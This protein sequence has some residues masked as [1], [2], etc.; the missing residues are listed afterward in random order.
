VNVGCVPSKIL[1]RAGAVA[2]RGGHHP[3]DGIPRAAGPVERSRLLAQLR[4]RVD[5]LR[6]SKYRGILDDNERITLVRGRAR[7]ED[8]RTLHVTL[9]NGGTQR[10]A[11]DRILIATGAS[12][13]L[14]AVPGLADTPWWSSTD[15]LFSDEVPE[16]L[17]VIGSSYVA[18]EI[19]QAYQ[20]LGTRVTILARSTLLSRADPE[21]GAELGAAFE[22]EGIR[23]LNQAHVHRV[24]YADGS[25]AL[26]TTHGPLEAERLLVATGRTPNTPGLNLRAADVE[27]DRFGAVRVNERLQS[28]NPV[29]YAVGDCAGLP[30]LVYVAAAAGTRAAINMTGGG[31]TLDLSVVPKVMFTDP[32]VAT[33]GMNEGEA[34]S[35]GIETDSRRLNLTEVPRAL[36]NFDERGFVKLVTEAQSGRLIGAQVV[37]Q[38][39]GE[40]IE[41]AALAIRHG[42]TA[43]DLAGELFPYLTMAEALKLCAQTFTRDVSQ[44]S[45]CAG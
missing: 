7:F 31:A 17:A 43:N 22:A 44:L 45:C 19:A 16:R 32:Q 23:V 28:S 26:A 41:T 40:I 38:A 21:I 1:L 24:D 10:I 12:P 34:R 35:E 36:V 11:P 2:Y 13:A 30:Q 6:Q 14:P 9:T 37:A 20:R 42:M 33:V 3:F 25:F 8:E 15:A 18:L 27:T 5:E 4:A 29:I 39:G